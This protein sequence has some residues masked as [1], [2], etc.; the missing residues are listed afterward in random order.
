[1]PRSMVGLL[2]A[3]GAAMAALAGS[4]HGDLFWV[5]VVDAATATGLASYLALPLAAN[6]KKSSTDFDAVTVRSAEGTL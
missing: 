3:V 2:A 5:I 4:A 1:M 6:K